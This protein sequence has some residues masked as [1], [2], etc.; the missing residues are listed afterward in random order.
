MLLDTLIRWLL[1]IKYGVDPIKNGDKV[2][3]K[4]GIGPAQKEGCP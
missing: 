1:T 3:M 2:P 4:N